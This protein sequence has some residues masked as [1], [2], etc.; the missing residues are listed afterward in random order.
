MVSQHNG[1]GLLRPLR[2][3]EGNAMDKI[4]LDLKEDVKNQIYSH[5]FILG[6]DAKR[7]S[8]L[9]GNRFPEAEKMSKAA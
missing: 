5:L 8:M 2:P 7:L 1:L 6:E 3:I 4:L 9:A